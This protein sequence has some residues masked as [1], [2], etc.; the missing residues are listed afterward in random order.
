MTSHRA[1]AAALSLVLLAG[2]AT[3]PRAAR[4]QSPDTTG[5]RDPAAARRGAQLLLPLGSTLLPGLGQYVQGAPL[6]GVALTAAAATGAAVALTHSSSPKRSTEAL[7][8]SLGAQM[9]QLSGAI[10]GYDSFRR[11]VPG[12]QR[13]GKYAFIASS[14]SV[15]DGITAPLDVRYLA[16]WTT[17]LNLAYTAGV[18]VWL[19]NDRHRGFQYEP[20][21]A[22]DA[23]F[24]FS[25][26]LTSPPGEEMLLRGWLFP[27][28][29][30]NLG[31]RL[32]LSNGLQAALFGAL[33][34]QAGAYAL[35]I[36][37]RGWY[38]GWL[39]ERNGW[40]VGEAIFNHF[41]YDAAVLTASLLTD[42]AEYI[43]LPGP[44]IRF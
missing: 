14:T 9:L 3:A 31:R 26:S 20:L 4:G 21:T 33:H 36:G 23:A 17:W 41:W 5:G 44:T 42:T 12:L 38:Y 30:E 11:S 8:R 16:R 35:V 28:L 1:Q 29:H 2:V 19:L 39:T 25:R 24:V 13:A 7:K 40:N 37:A 18:T 34:P 32:W 43:I 27:L 10:S 6:L 22:R 15:G